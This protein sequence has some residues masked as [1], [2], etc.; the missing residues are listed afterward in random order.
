MPSNYRA[1]VMAT[2][3]LAVTACATTGATGS[4]ARPAAAA[5]KSQQPVS[6]LSASFASPSAGLALAE[7]KCSDQ[8]N[9][10][11]TT[12]LIRKTVDGG[13]TWF[14]APAPPAP[15]ATMSQSSQPPD[16]V[17][18]I[19]F[20]SARDGWAYDPGLWRTRDGSAS[21]QRVPVPGPVAGFTVS[22]GQMLAVIG[23]CDSS[24]N[25]AYRGYTARAGTSAWRPLPG[26]A[27]RTAGQEIPQLAVSGTTGYLVA[28]TSDIAKPVLLAGPVTG[29]A[30]WR[31]LPVP[32]PAAWSA[33]VA[34]VPG[35]LFL[36]CGS[37][38]GA[39]NQQKTAYLSRDG[40]R[41]WH[42]L[43]GPPLGGYL[44]GA[45]MTAGGT[46]FLSGGRM[47]VYI[48]RD[49]GRSWHESPSLAN[50]AGLA[51]AGLSLVATTVTGTFGVAVQQQ[52]FTRQV[53]LTRDGGRD[54]SAVT[55]R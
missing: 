12:V 15:P 17:G 36:G 54:W 20:T 42:T 1:F 40:G 3:L 41:T 6:V 47:D 27:L 32:C 7:P 53:W 39:G 46:I 37:E 5:A 19:L 34:A 10:C 11:K 55:L 4:G 24:G 33:A 14:S 13:R 21:W 51:N 38:P 48:S 22:G 23:G 50:A 28:L 44:N 18:Q 43:A 9:P 29:S 31:A 30:R 35:S 2:A 45:T 16:A 25:C 49:R 26:T 52:V 8:V